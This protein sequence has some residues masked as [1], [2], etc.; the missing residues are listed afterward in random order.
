MEQLEL[1]EPARR[2]LAEAGY[3]R[4]FPPQEAAVRAGLLRGRSLVVSSPTGSGKSLI[5]LLAAL[6]AVAGG[7]RAVYLAPLRSLVYERAR[8]WRRL[9]GEGLGAR[10]AVATGDYDRVEP[11]LADADAALLTY[12]KFDSLLRH[13]ASW[14]Y[15]V[16]VLVVDEVHY[17]GDPGRGPTLEAALARFLARSGASTQI[18]AMS[19]TVPNA[20]EIAEWLGAELVVSEWR[21]VPL[22]EG[23]LYRGEITWRDAERSSV[24]RV[25]GVEAL[26]AALDTV[27]DGGQAIVFVQSRRRAEEL[28]ER[29]ASSRALERRELPGWL[30]EA[31][32]LQEHRRLNERL[33]SLAGRGVA[34]HH[35]GLASYQREAIERLFRERLVDVLVATTTLAAGVNLPAR[36]V[37]VDSLYRFRRGRS[38]AIRVSEYKQLAGRAG[39]PGL[40]ER[41]EAVIVAR[42]E[43]QF[44]NA[45]IHYVNGEP[46]PV[47][48]MLASEKALRSQVLAI[49]ASEG[50]MYPEEL[51]AVLNRT[52]YASKRGDLLFHV[53]RVAGQL[54]EMGL[55]RLDGGVFEAT[56]LG[57]R[58]A[59]LYVDPITVHRMY[60][61][62]RRVERFD[63][64]RLLFLALWNSDSVLLRPPRGSSYMEEAEEELASL[65]FSDYD[66]Y[67][68]A[69]AAQALYTVDMLVD[70]VSELPEE[71]LLA[72][73]GIEPGD[74]RAVVEAAEWLVYALREVARLQGHPLAGRIEALRWMVKYGVAE[75]LVE[76]VKLP[77]I[78]RVRAR[79]LY[80]SGVRTAEDVAR[81]GPD[82]LQRL[83]RGLGR[84]GAEQASAAAAGAP[85]A[86]RRGGGGKGR[87]RSLLDYLGG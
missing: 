62:L 53:K 50:A 87:G 16:D 15:S 77:G 67:D 42:G 44:W 28:A 59:Q 61:G 43:E 54:E 39:R 2:V 8:E 10:V 38:E 22:R 55:L 4:L 24:R 64:H 41:G 84:R 72:K 18:V 32:S 3:H 49:V 33:L 11:W 73:Y 27:R 37:V 60:T 70:W 47:E 14:L 25:T 65:G 78:G 82:G 17:V 12:E 6:R 68:L 80:Q 31:L 71:E 29:L 75:E 1:P 66:N 63:V 79:I 19:A 34:F 9:L 85:R 30:Y 76:L 23:V 86:S 69:V 52:L 45:L 48:S 58:A 36:R 13:G 40:D 74:L 83:L 7:G 56:A 57:R 5:G 46:E 51:L 35:A 81:L 21:P 20:G 26:D